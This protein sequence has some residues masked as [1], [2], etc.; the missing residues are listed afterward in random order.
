MAKE[1]KYPKAQDGDSI[2]RNGPR[3][4]RAK[5]DSLASAWPDFPKGDYAGASD[6]DYE[7]ALREHAASGGAQLIGRHARLTAPE[8]ND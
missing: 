1:P 4:L 2:T 5:L 7:A 8:S 3:S 6:A